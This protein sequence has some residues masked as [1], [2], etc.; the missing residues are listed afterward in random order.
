[1][2][3]FGCTKLILSKTE[4]WILRL[5]LVSVLPER[6][7]SARACSAQVYKNGSGHER[8][9]VWEKTWT[10]WSVV[11]RLEERRNRADLLEVFKMYKGWSSSSFDSLFTLMDNS[12]TR[13]HSAKIVKNTCRLDMRRYFS[14]QRVIDRWNPL[15]QSVIDSATINAFK[16]GL[17][18]TR[19]VSI[20]FFTD[21]QFAKP[22][23]LI[24]SSPEPGVATPGMYLV[25]KDVCLNIQI[26]QGRAAT[27]LRKCG[28]FYTDLLR[29]SQL[30]A[31]LKELLNSVSICR[32]YPDTK[33]S[34]FYGPVY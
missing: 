20:G 16:T 29:S 10:Y 31:R 32:S 4:S 21:W 18:R 22:Y 3:C 2:S 25:C 9:V 33:S 17:S 27:N 7:T 24:F 1:M 11:T 12:R 8:A 23:G 14:S 15:K 6:Q 34:T 28:K 13:G 30:T 19:N 26:S 5:C